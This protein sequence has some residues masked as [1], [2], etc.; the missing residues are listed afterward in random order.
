MLLLVIVQIHLRLDTN[1]EQ[2]KLPVQT[3]ISRHLGLGESQQQHKQQQ[4]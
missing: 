2:E 3:Y 1:L 4:Q